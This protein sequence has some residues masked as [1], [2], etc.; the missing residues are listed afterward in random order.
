M[1]NETF[2]LARVSPVSGRMNTVEIPCSI[3]AY[4][5]GYAAWKKG[6]LIQDAF[7]F[8]PASIREFIMSGITPQ[9]W[10]DMFGSAD[11]V[12]DDN[13]EA[14]IGSTEPYNNPYSDNVSD[15]GFDPYSNTYTDDC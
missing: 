8:L 10:D 13:D 1:T 15:E 5:I 14:A 3:E 11:D 2:T 7:P 12:D 9:E 6:A 4:A